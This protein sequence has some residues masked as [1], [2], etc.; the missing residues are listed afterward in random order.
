MSDYKD[1]AE[2]VIAASID[3][4]ALQFDE[5]E[6]QEF[7]YLLM[8]FDLL[9]QLLASHGET[10]AGCTQETKDWIAHKAGGSIQ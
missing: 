3:L 7:P 5:E 1:I 8:A 4:I 2:S 6:V 10:M 9:N